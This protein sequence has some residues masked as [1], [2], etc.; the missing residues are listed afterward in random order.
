MH[1]D[2]LIIGA[3]LHIKFEDIDPGRSGSKQRRQRIGRGMA[4]AASVG[5]DEGAFLGAPAPS[6]CLNRFRRPQPLQSPSEA[7]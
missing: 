4:E 2:Q 3:E 7:R 1:K 5:N 6:A